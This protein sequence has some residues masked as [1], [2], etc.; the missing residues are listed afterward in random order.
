ML[1]YINNAPRRRLLYDDKGDA[2]ITCYLN[3]DWAD[4]YQIRDP[5]L[6]IVFLLE[7]I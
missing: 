7:E 2:K 3:V 5:L 1:R 4:H 6:D